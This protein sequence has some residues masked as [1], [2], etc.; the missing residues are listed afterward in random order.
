MIFS[1]TPTTE[2]IVFSAYFVFGNVKHGMSCLGPQ[3][4]I[5]ASNQKKF[6]FIF[7]KRKTD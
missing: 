6:Y 2:C 3:L 1:Y 7:F 4:H 5:Y